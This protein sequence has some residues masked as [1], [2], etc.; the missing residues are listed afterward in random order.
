MQYWKL[1]ELNGKPHAQN[2]TIQ[3]CTFTTLDTIADHP[4]CIGYTNTIYN[5]HVNKNVSHYM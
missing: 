1:L 5:H 4:I 2:N 3:S